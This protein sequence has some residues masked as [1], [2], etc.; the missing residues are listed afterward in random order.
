MEDER[1]DPTT[2]VTLKGEVA[3]GGGRRRREGWMEREGGREGRVRAEPRSE[4]EWSGR[5][6][7]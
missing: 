3:K 4:V 6:L 1:R 7:S 2:V 5:K